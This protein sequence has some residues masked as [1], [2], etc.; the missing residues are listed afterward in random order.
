MTMGLCFNQGKEFAGCTY[1]ICCFYCDKIQECNVCCETVD[2]FEGH[3]NP[4]ECK[5]ECKY[6]KEKIK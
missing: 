3:E 4:I 5:E 1:D 6:C 2:N